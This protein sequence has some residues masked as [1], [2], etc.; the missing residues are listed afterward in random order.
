MKPSYYFFIKKFGGEAH[1]CVLLWLG[2]WDPFGGLLGSFWCFMSFVESSGPG[3]LWISS[4]SI[5]IGI[6]ISIS[7]SIGMV[8]RGWVGGWVGG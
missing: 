3:T 7:I 1:L 8:V 2:V 6:S 4:I 5:G